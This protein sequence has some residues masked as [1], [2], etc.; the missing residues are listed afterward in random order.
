MIAILDTMRGDESYRTFQLLEVQSIRSCSSNVFRRFTCRRWE[1]LLIGMIN[2]PATSES[3]ARLRSSS[4]TRFDEALGAVASPANLLMLFLRLCYKLSHVMSRV[5]VVAG[6]RGL[7]LHM[8]PCVDG[9]IPVGP[10]ETEDGNSYL[11][12][13]RQAL[14][15]CHLPSELFAS[16]D[17]N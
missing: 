14:Q 16:T 2:L 3:P 7:A 8:S 13:S 5:S 4:A 17:G 11:P 12:S 9:A 1:D 6:R 15:V 10:T